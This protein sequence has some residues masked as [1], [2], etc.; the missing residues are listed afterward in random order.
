MAGSIIHV[1]IWR[2]GIVPSGFAVPFI[3]KQ[4]TLPANDSASRLYPVNKA[5]AGADS[6]MV[7]KSQSP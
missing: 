4:F 6:D 3:V 1:K 2:K 7:C 5:K